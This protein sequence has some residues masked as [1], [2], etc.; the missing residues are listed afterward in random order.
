MIKIET[1]SPAALR[2][3]EGPLALFLFEEGLASHP[4]SRARS[5]RIQDLARAE[6]AKGKAGEVVPVSL[7]GAR[8]LLTGLGKRKAFSPEALR[9]ACAALARYSQPRTKAL[10]VLVPDDPGGK[11]AARDLAL[12]AAEGLALATYRYTRYRNGSDEEK[13]L[14]QRAVLLA[15]AGDRRA[16]EEGVRKARVRVEAVALVRDL[17]NEGPSDKKPEVLA[18]LAR[19]MANGTSAGLK[20]RVLGPGEMRRLGMNAILGVAR[21]SVVEPRFVHMTY[22][23]SGR[24]RKRVAL[25][26]KGITFDSGGLSLKT[27]QNMEEMK[28]DMAGAAVVL[29]VLQAL[30]R[31]KLPVE[32]HGFAP[33]TY[34]LPGGDALKPGDVLK[35]FNGKTI[36]VLNT[37]AEGRLVLSD[38]LAFACKLGFDSII[39]LA[40]LTG[41]ALIALGSKVTAALSNDPGLAEALRKAGDRN[42]ERIWELPLV[43]EYREGLKSKVAD[44][45]NISSVRGEA[46]T[47]IG[48][49]FLKEFV[50]ETPWVHL[51]IAGTAW[52]GKAEGYLSPG[53]TG[54]MVRTLLDYLE[55][56]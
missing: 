35:A 39:D 9:R 28:M 38:A 18:A 54:A 3:K 55:G 19:S 1:Q 15:P 12:A 4:E 14:L 2:F 45:Q 56:L 40:T 16:A 7:D 5:K 41:A 33:F 27:P 44:L 30:P 51:D 8:L 10:G 50:D 47:I 6:N 37:D 23:P 52:S 11:T 42:G 31:L 53:G 21:G 24:A 49:L 26:G 48:G 36:E 17:V 29:A 32:V 43:E 20:V 13:P 34:N 25:V 22:R 46:G